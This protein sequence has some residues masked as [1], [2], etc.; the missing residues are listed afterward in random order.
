MADRLSHSSLGVFRQC[1]QKYKFEKVDKLKVPKPVYAHQ[2]IGNAVHRQVRKAYEWGAEGRL[3]PLEEMLAAF[4]QEW[5]G[6]KRDKVTPANEGRTIDDDI[7]RG[8]RMLERFYE[9]HKPFNRGTHLFAEKTFSFFL[10]NCPVRFDARV[11]RVWK[12]ED[13]VYEIS[14]FKTGKIVG[15]QDPGFRLQMGFYQLALQESFPDRT[16]EVAQYFLEYDEVVSYR[17]R[18]DE[19]EELA[20]QFR[21]EAHE[22]SRAERMG[23]WPPNPTSLCAW[24]EFARLCPAMKHKLV[25][26]SAQE[27]TEK[28]TF[29]EAARLAEECLDLHARKK[30]LEGEYALL[31]ER[32]IQSAKE[33]RLSRFDTAQGYV[34]VK[35]SRSEHIDSR[36][37]EPARHAALTALVRAWDDHVRDVCLRLDDAALLKLHQ[38]GRLNPTQESQLAEFLSI[39]ES[40]K[41]IPHL[42]GSSGSDDSPEDE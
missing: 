31:R 23:E 20:E 19:L 11:D 1:P 41:V 27:T 33:L 6:P 36:T 13:G 16:Y 9:R 2:V 28:A 22:I 17:M 34:S 12:R 42:K 21:A 15:P 30:E 14:D 37:E 4:D 7:A 32:L 3:Y 25:M 5:E 29:Q 38:K 24:C 8:R 18:P 26:E 10:P 40:A 35:I 39:K